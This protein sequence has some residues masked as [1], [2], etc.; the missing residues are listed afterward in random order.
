MTQPVNNRFPFIA[1]LIALVFAA[2][3]AVYAWAVTPLWDIP[4]E[5][6]HYSYA[7]DM[8]RGKWPR[9]GQAKIGA[10]VV[11]S[12]INPQAGPRNNWIAQH[13]P[14][15]YALEAPVLWATRAAHF[16]LEQRVRAARTLN[17]LLGGLTVLGL[18]LFLARATE[19]EELGLAGAIF[20]AA[21]PMFT[22]LS[23]GVTHDILVACT[24][25]WAAYWCVRWLESNLFRHLLY[26]G[27]LV[28]LA[29]ITK[30]TSLA[31]AVPLF[32]VLSL[33]LWWIGPPSKRLF[34]WLGRGTVLWLVM[35]TPICLWIVHN[36]IQFG[37]PLP[38]AA[39]LHP[40]QVVPIGF[41]EFMV[42]FPVWE[43]TLLNF[44]A[45]VGWNGS[46][47]GTL[48]WIQP[49]GLTAR[50]FLGF[51]GTTS[52]GVLALLG[53][54]YLA[55]QVR[56]AVAALGLLAAAYVYWHY[57]V[58]NLV[59]WTC[60]LLLAALIA[61]LA[62]NA[63]ELFGAEL[64]GWLLAAAA[65]CSLLFMLIY[66]EHL[67]GNFVGGM[68]ATHGRYLYPVVP[69]LLL[70]LV[71][72]FRSAIARCGLLYAATAAMLFADGFYLR[73]VFDLY[74]QTSA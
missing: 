51:I 14:L 73:H 11:Q 58:P 44:I 2:K 64:S 37:Q 52:L 30:I 36:Q 66:F 13:P 54:P 59:V 12:W 26:A 1:S 19:C 45:L 4:D 65:I 27:I 42:R 32:F 21:T 68:R 8:S 24:A 10:E 55:I 70:V 72:P 31:L 18:A 71:W 6:G 63:K 40:V 9:L 48:A 39:N 49:T 20:F 17:A 22:H 5:P 41:F 3:F 33:R 60:F 25:A 38:D 16:D 57:P 50:Y 7:E 35:F 15:F 23:T 74:G 69:F 67:R 62:T 46:G 29:T 56:H 28:A 53:W 61:T 43:H 34:P 47:N